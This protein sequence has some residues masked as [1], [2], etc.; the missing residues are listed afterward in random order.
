MTAC[1]LG[2]LA[3]FPIGEDRVDRL[4]AICTGRGYDRP[5]TARNAPPFMDLTFQKRRET[6]AAS[7]GDPVEQLAATRQL[8]WLL[9]GRPEGSI[10]AEEWWHADEEAGMERQR[11]A[12]HAA[13]AVFR[14]G[15]VTAFLHVLRSQESVSAKGGAKDLERTREIALEAIALACVAQPKNKEVMRLRRTK[16]DQEGEGVIL[17]MRLI[18]EGGEGVKD[19]GAA[20]LAEVCDNYHPCRYRT[21]LYPP[22]PQTFEPNPKTRP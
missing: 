7:A 3:T 13:D 1:C 5:K 8:V 16:F 6:H 21:P 12:A 22:L 11:Q 10:S 17:V 20:A 15:G 14:S 18:R 19:R 4:A 9:G 2:A